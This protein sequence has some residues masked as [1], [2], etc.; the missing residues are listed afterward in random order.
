MVINYITPFCAI[1]PVGM[2]YLVETGIA[3]SNMIGNQHF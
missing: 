3:F 2:S 1:G